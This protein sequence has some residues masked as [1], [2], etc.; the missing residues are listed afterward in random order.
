ME[1]TSYLLQIII[2]YM[3]NNNLSIDKATFFTVIIG[4]ITIYGIL[5][6]FYQFVASYQGG[7]KAATRYLGINITEYFVKKKIKI[8]N[9][10]IS[11][12]M[13]GV[14]LILEILS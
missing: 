2:D 12:K 1:R 9:K 6:T 4:Q 3:F 5:L 10:I 7:E 13:F 8:F 14:L 11:K